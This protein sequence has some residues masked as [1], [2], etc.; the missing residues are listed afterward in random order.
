MTYSGLGDEA[1][2][3]KWAKRGLGGGLVYTAKEQNVE[4][5]TSAGQQ[6]QLSLPLNQTLGQVHLQ[7]CKQ[8]KH[9]T[10]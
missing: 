2:Y 6:V 9:I 5:E 7:Q 8:K 4:V 1:V 3:S 10:P